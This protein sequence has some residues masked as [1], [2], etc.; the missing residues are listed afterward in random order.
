MAKNA[1]RIRAVKGTRDILPPESRLWLKVEE[2]CRDIL[3]AYGFQEIRTP[4]FEETEL[5]ARSVG[6]NTDIV[7]KEMYSF[8]DRDGRS[9]TLRPEATASVM[10]AY[11]DSGA[12]NQGGVKKYYYSGPMFRRERPQKGRFR[13]F[14]QI[15]AEV[16]GSDHPT[17]DVEVLEMLDLLLERLSLTGSVLLLNSVGCS[18][19]RPAYVEALQSS[20]ESVAS[21]MCADC[22]RRASTN[23]LRVLDCKVPAD[24][25]I[26]EGLPKILDYLCSE[27]SG[28]FRAVTS[29]LDRRKIRYTITPRLVRGLDYYTRTTFEIT[30][31]GLGS[32]NALLGGGRYDGLSELI[33]GPPVKGLGFAIGEDRFLMA[34][35]QSGALASSAGP[36]VFVAWMGEEAREAALG[37]ARQL[38]REGIRTEIVFDP[39][40]IKKS[41][42]LANK[43]GA[44]WTLIVGD[45]EVKRGLFQIKDMQ[46]GRQEE[47]PVG[48]L[49]EEMRARRNESAPV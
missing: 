32:Q 44:R 15:G 45:D 2:I 17:V 11:L 5:F 29:G 48:R 46:T 21:K 34:V 27:C 16:L 28:H 41:L 22:R 49:M 30:H 1:E 35:E 20:L 33:G 6:T 4:I 47:F 26:I 3:D 12:V 36:E 39:I 42:A 38:R 37:A 13:Q 25:P 18:Q 14:Y 9:L 24:Q 43:L 31:S 7:S 23:P 10:R 19:C 8:E 40:N